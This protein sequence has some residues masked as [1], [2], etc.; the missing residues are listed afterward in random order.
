[1]CRCVNILLFSNET[2][3]VALTLDI[4]LICMHDERNIY[5]GKHEGTP[6]PILVLDIMWPMSQSHFYV[7]RSCSLK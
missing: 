7:S 2:N 5:F 6:C 1:M 4:E 3:V